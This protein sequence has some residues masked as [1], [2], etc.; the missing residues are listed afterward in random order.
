MVN[1]EILD[2]KLRHSGRYLQPFGQNVGLWGQTIPSSKCVE[3]G[4][5][6]GRV[7]SVRQTISVKC[8]REQCL[9]HIKILQNYCEGVS[10][11]RLDF[12][13]GIRIGGSDG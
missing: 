2:P 7:G 1:V 8:W 5:L 6:G 13:V 9:G 4:I 12:A 11:I 3:T 10:Q